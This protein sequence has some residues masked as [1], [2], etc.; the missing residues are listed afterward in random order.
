MNGVITG[1]S[2]MAQAYSGMAGAGAYSDG[3]WTWTYT[4]DQA[5]F[6]LTVTKTSNGYDW[7][8]M[9]SGILDE[10][11]VDNWKAAEGHCN[12]DGTE[13]WVK[14]YEVNTTTVEMSWK[15]EVTSDSKSGDWWVYEGDMTSEY[16]SW[17]AHWTTDSSGVLTCWMN[18][19]EGEWKVLVVCPQDG[20]SEFYLNYEGSYPS[21]ESAEL[22]VTWTGNGAHGQWWEPYEGPED[23]PDGSW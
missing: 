16:L 18:D 2:A 11:T 14:I 4:E 1:F 15:W 7:K 3:H 19:M 17:E 6:K 8:W 21:I 5:T 10:E 9:V 20:T 13:G 23:E 22:K 12:N